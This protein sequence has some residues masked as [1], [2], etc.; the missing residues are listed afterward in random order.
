MPDIDQYKKAILNGDTGLLEE[1]TTSTGYNEEFKSIDDF[2]D[3]GIKFAKTIKDRI[4]NVSNELYK[5]P[6]SYNMPDGGFYF[7][8]KIKDLKMDGQ[9]FAERL[10]NEK[11]VCVTP[12]TAFGKNYKYFFRMS[13]CQ[14]YNI[15]L[16][17]IQKMEDFF[18]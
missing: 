4:R 18:R 10:L 9:V 6:L 12:G 5:M 11:G 2:S 3:F 13:V 8:P 17:A 7:F 15:L 16:E 14:P 1:L